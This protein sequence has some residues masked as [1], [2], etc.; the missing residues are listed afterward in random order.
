MM[1]TIISFL[2]I[3]IRKI[4]PSWLIKSRRNYMAA[5]ARKGAAKALKNYE[6]L[7]A[8]QVFTKIYE[9]GHWGQSPNSDQ[10]FFSGRGSHDADIVDTY[11]EAVSAF[12]SSFVTKP[13]VVDLGCGDFTVGSKLRALCGRYVACDIVEPVISW[14]KQRYSDDDVDFCVLD[15]S[16]DKLPAGDIVFVRQ[17]LQHMSNTQIENVLSQIIDKYKYLILTEHLPATV[18]FAH[19]LDK[20]VGPDIRLRLNSG[21]VLTSPPFNLPIRQEIKLCE[22]YDSRLAEG[23][24]SKGVIRTTLYQLA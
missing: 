6:G 20:P 1:K 2:K 23:A 24:N 5:R 16:H 18:A 17:V 9:E 4:S 7:S 21:I 12:L 19:N 10:R 15:I 22:F 14:N 11:V 8:Q 3:P 13:N